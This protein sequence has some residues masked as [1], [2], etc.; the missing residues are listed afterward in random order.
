VKDP[1]G[2]LIEFSYG[3]PLGPGASD[4]DNEGP[5]RDAGDMTVKPLD[6]D[7]AGTGS[8]GRVS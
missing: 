3:Q 6:A 5:G 8:E 1:D 2:N 4:L 7:A